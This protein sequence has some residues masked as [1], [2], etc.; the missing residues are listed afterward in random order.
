MIKNELKEAFPNT[1]GW[2][3]AFLSFLNRVGIS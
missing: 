3:T 1:L 2:E